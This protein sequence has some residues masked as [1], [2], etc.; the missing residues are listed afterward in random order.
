MKKIIDSGGYRIID[1]YT[2]VNVKVVDESEFL[3]LDP[4]RESFINLNTPEEL[5]L[6]ERGKRSA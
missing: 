1:V 3:S 5:L 2:M 4:R 6:I